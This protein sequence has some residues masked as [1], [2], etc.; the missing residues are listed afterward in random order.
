MNG[1][2]PVDDHFDASNSLF[3]LSKFSSSCY[4]KS[5]KS[6][7]YIKKNNNDLFYFVAQ[8]PL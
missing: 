2:A 7:L 5:L 4:K 8:S 3:I 1:G 6:S